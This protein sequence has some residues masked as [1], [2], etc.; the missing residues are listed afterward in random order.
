[1]TDK[2]TQGPWLVNDF[3]ITTGDSRWLIAT[4]SGVGLGMNEWEA[5]ARLIAVAPELLAGALEAIAAWDMEQDTQEH[6]H[7]ERLEAAIE[8]LRAAIAKAGV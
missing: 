5:N 6:N 3:D 1:M 2:H 7:E 4:A 8:M